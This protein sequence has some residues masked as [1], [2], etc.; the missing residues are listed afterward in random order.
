MLEK[1]RKIL[2]VSFRASL[3]KIRRNP[4]LTSRVLPDEPGH[5]SRRLAPLVSLFVCFGFFLI[6]EHEE[7]AN[8]PKN[9]FNP[10][11]TQGQFKAQT[12]LESLNKLTLLSKIDIVYSNHSPQS[13]IPLPFF[14]GWWKCDWFVRLQSL[15]LFFLRQKGTS[16]YTWQVPLET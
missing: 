6:F 11:P 8:R 13:R 9:S 15:M 5:S 4:V 16:L 14:V 7:Q 2:G 12:D 10:F 1:F 3:Q